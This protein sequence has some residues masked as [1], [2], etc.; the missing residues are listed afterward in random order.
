MTATRWQPM[1]DSPAGTKANPTKYALLRGKHP[2]ADFG[3]WLEDD[4]HCVWAD[5]FNIGAISAESLDDAVEQLGE[6]LEDLLSRW[7]DL[8]DGGEA[9]AENE[10]QLLRRLMA[11]FAR[12]LFQE[13]QTLEQRDDYLA[14]WQMGEQSRPGSF[15]ELLNV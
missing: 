15:N 6:N 3:Y 14:P 13:I 7:L 5:E 11:R 2:I 8:L 10:I 9:L 4:H 1:T 12:A